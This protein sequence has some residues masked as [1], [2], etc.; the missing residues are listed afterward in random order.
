[1]EEKT[2]IPVGTSDMPAPQTFAYN[3][4]YSLTELFKKD[5]TAVLKELSYADANMFFNEINMYPQG[6]PAAVL[7]QFIRALG[8]L[9]YKYV[10][11]L[12]KSIETKGNFEK[13]FTLIEKKEEQK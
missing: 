4:S 5:L 8:R 13:Y 1:M 2:P 7:N 10:A 9:P 11:P 3:K 6:M 12:M